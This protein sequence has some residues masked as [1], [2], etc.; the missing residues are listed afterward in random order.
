MIMRAP[1]DFPPPQLRQEDV[2]TDASAEMGSRRW[3]EIFNKTADLANLV[4]DLVS[5]TLGILLVMSLLLNTSGFGY[6][7]S[8]D[9]ITIQPLDDMRR[10]NAE[11][12][13]EM[14]A[15]RLWK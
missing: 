7:M 6:T 11:R 9:G 2:E 5:N 15:S 10:E 13:F 3:S 8:P 14:E 4:M 12:R 1:E